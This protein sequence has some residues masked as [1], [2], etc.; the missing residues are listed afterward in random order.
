MNKKEAIRLLVNRGST[1]ADADRA[2]AAVDFSTNPDEITILKA[3]CDFAGSELSN[4]QRLQAA[5]RA[6]VT[7]RNQEI[8]KKDR[9]YAAK[10]Q[11]VENALKLERSYWQEVLGT[12][13]SFA[14]RLGLKDPMIEHLLQKDNDRDDAA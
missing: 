12:V 5:Q 8:E 14:N 13:Y 6:V 11:Q 2:L 3:F 1:K 4:R 7:K 10:I 9:D